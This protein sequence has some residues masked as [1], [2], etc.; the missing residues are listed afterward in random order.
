[1]DLIAPVVLTRPAGRNAPL[2]AALRAAGLAVVEAPAL[3]IERLAVAPPVLQVGDLCVFVS[4]QAVDACFDGRCAA[5][6]WPDGVR[7]AAVGA[8]TAQALRLHVPADAIL[9]PAEGAPPDSESLLAVIEA[10]GL[11][12]GRAHIMRAQQGRDWLA[13]QL[14][15]RGWSVYCHALYRRSPAIWDRDTCA[16]LAGPGRCTLLLTSLE[17]VDAVADSLRRQAMDWPAT[18]KLVTLHERIARRLQ[19]I[20]AD[21]PADALTVRLS[22]PDEAALFQ[23]IL[24]SARSA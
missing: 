6:P 4:R 5:T 21:R 8:A 17:A 20:Y 18:L 16:I 22:A 9:A 3:K 24:A 13:R 19:C 15:A 23:A 2:A 11:V 1:M 7:A 14:Q 10:V 12:P